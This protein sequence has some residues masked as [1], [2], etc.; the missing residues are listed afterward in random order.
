MI[1]TMQ[2]E[3]LPVEMTFLTGASVMFDA[4]YVPGGAKV[5]KC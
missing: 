2:G 4:V 3:E 1:Q 5:S